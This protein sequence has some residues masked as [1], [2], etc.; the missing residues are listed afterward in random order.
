MESEPRT[1]DLGEDVRASSVA[2]AL[3]NVPHLRLNT[4]FYSLRYTLS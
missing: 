2:N 1:R 4:A 3:G